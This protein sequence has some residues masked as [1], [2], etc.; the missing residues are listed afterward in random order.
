MNFFS[1]TIKSFKVLIVGL[2]LYVDGITLGKTHLLL[3][4]IEDGHLIDSVFSTPLVLEIKFS[5]L[6]RNLE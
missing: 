3:R 4:S 5:S 2:N 6:L 1:N